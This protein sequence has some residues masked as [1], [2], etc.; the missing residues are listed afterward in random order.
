MADHSGHNDYDHGYG[1]QDHQHQGN[2]E[3]YYQD[4]Q[5]YHDQHGAYDHNGQQHNNDGY[6]DEA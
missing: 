2:A 1:Q 6:Y 3:P 5:Q 4:D